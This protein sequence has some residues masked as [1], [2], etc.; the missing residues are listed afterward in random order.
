M[1]IQKNTFERFI[2][3]IIEEAGKSRICR[4][5]WQAETKEKPVLWL[6]Y[7]DHQAETPRKLVLQ[8]KSEAVSSL[9]AGL[10][11]EKGVSFW[12]FFLSLQLIRQGPP[13]MGG[14]VLLKICH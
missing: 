6:K 9:G 13:I 1:Y 3:V 5:G 11:W 4:V 10:R 14:Q 2:H 12:F 7:K 8:L